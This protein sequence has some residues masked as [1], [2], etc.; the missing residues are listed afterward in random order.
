MIRHFY[1][2][3]GARKSLLLSGS[4]AFSAICDVKMAKAKT[5]IS[6]AA[7]PPAV[8][9]RR[10]ARNVKR[11]SED[12]HSIVKQEEQDSPVVK[13]SRSIK[14]ETSV[15]ASPPPSR[16]RKRVKVEDDAHDYE[17]RDALSP[18]RISQGA[19]SRSTSTPKSERKISASP[20]P[21]TKAK[22]PVKSNAAKEDI[23][24]AKKLKSYSQFATAS[25]YPDFLRPTAAECKL[26]RR[27]LERQHGERERPTTGPSN[28]APTDAAGC[29]A[30]PSVL[31]ALVRTIL[32]QNTSSANSTRAKRSMD[33]EY[34]GSD[35]WEAI[36]AG[37][38][39]R[40]QRA[41]EGGGLA[42]VKSRV[43]LSILEQAHARH[44][45]YS[46]DHLFAAGDD[47]AMRELISF[48]GVGPKTAS[49]VL[50]FCLGRQSFAVDT[51]VHRITGLLGWRPP[52]ASRDETY[53][54]LN[55]RIPDEDK[56][57]LHVLLVTHGRICEECRAGG[58]SAG[59]CEL[60]R[61]FK[62]GVFTGDADEDLG[63]KETKGI[64]RENSSVEG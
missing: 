32:S 62:G 33:A 6:A 12:L 3:Q 20:P 18:P 42:A 38:Q 29:G 23:L 2:R 17:N 63:I 31:D 55:T 27:I 14:R 36:A 19:K 53:A 41:I 30:S 28:L 9:L 7:G 10:S 52:A 24:Q 43:I 48:R 37:G 60:R 39:E 21:S 49:C 5:S 35:Q 50:L 56:Y 47:D 8:P 45:A 59:K 1:R 26:A 34:G 25:P 57:A 46:L 40:L 22:S 51:H 64:K 13:R 44:G 58:K 4:R 11:E 16:R 54:H 61:A 15:I